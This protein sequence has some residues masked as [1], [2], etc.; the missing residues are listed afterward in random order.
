MLL[1]LACASTTEQE[2][3]ILQTGVALTDAQLADARRVGVVQ[4]ERVRLLRVAQIPTPTHPGLAAASALT[5]LI[6]PSTTGLTVRY[7]VF[8]RADCWRQRPLVAHEL[9]HTTQYE[10][11]GG[12]D[13]FLRPHLLDCITSPGYPH[14]PIEQETIAVSARLCNARHTPS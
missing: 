9:V 11:L 4:P 7:G 10:R 8:V 12:F 1:F 13:A 14:G 2:R 5:H 3:I 6:S